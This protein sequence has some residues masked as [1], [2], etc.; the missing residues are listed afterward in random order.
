MEGFWPRAVKEVSLAAVS[1]TVFCLLAVS[2]LAVFVRAYAPADTVITFCN[3]AIKWIGAFG[4]AIVFVRSERA[5]FK[6]M[7]AGL[8]MF[9]LSTL[10][11]G[12][13]GGWHFTPWI[14]LEVS[15]SC[16]FG[17]LGAFCGGK[18]RKD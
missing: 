1:G 3:Q 2:L 14:A 4:G 10:L 15:L 12:L 7:A 11:F 5:L 17:G 18:T 13:I 16:I 9:L 6:G 8:A